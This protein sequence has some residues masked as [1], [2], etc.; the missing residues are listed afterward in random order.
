[1]SLITN[2]KL[3]LTFI[4]EIMH[5]TINLIHDTHEKLS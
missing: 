2:S 1:M 3:L 5:Y 4:T